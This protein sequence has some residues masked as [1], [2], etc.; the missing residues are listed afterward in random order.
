M[1][2]HRASRIG[3]ESEEVPKGRRFE[4][5]VPFKGPKIGGRE[6]VR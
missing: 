6:P 2:E 4:I 1:G 5:A 3:G